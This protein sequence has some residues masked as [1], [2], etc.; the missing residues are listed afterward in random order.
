MME[1]VLVTLI[2][3]LLQK[4]V[5]STPIV[6]DSVLLGFVQSARSAAKP[7]NRH[8]EIKNEV[9]KYTIDARQHCI[10]YF[11]QPQDS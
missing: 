1:L 5:C 4:G 2:L 7:I 10:R 11:L 8:K 9:A 3:R 6:P